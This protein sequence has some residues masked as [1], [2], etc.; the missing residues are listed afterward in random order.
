MYMKIHIAFQSQKYSDSF[1]PLATNGKGTKGLVVLVA[2]VPKVS[3]G[4]GM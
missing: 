3:N 1:A 2:L 4:L